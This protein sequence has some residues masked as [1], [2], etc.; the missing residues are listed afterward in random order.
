[1]TN[2]SL[3][4]TNE[5]YNYLLDNSLREPVVLEK[6]RKETAKI[7]EHNMQ[8]SPEQ[9]QFISFILKLI[10][11]KKTIEV[12]VFTGYSSLIT[13]MS[14]PK[15]GKVIACDISEKWTFIAKKY[16]KE[17]KVDKKIELN[18]APASETLSNL[19]DK[20]ASGKFDFAFID[21]DKTGYRNYYELCLKLIRQGGVIMFDNVLWSGRV[22]DESCKEEDDIALRELNKFLHHDER[23]DLSMLPLADGITIVRKR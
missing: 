15:E 4:L 10:N 13:A 17:A 6:L 8:I 11:A 12:G 22:A 1:M 18:I 3:N 16:W 9:G 21:A 20:G 14:L 19:I 23:V 7:E 5:V 2:K